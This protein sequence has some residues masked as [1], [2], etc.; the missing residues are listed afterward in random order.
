MKKKP[1]KLD[2]MYLEDFLTFLIKENKNYTLIQGEYIDH[3]YC[4]LFDYHFGSDTGEYIKVAEV[5]QRVK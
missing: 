2:G 4:G 3:V 1:Y 5:L